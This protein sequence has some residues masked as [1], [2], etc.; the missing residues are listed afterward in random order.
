[1]GKIQ[2]LETQLSNMIAA[3]EV[4]E[5]PA[6]V[7]KELVENAIDANAT[8]IE[9]TIEHAG[10]ILI[11]VRDNGDGMDR[12]DIAQSILRHATSKIKDEYDLFRIKTLGFRGEALPSIASVSSLTIESATGKGPGYKLKSVD[13]KVDIVPIASRKGTSVK[14]ENLFFNTP[15]RLKFLKNDYIETANIIDTITRIALGYPQIAFS[16]FIDGKNSFITDGRGDILQ[17][18]TQ[19]FGLQTA[20]QLTP[21]VFNSH[22]VKVSGYLG[23]PSLAKSHRYALY[24]LVNGRSV[25]L[26]KI[27]QALFEA[28]RPY[29]PPVRYPWLFLHFTVDPSLV[30]VNVHPTK[31]EVRLSKEEQLKAALIPAIRSTLSSLNLAP[32][33]STFYPQN[34]PQSSNQIAP[35]NAELREHELTQDWIPLSL[36]DSKSIQKLTV[37]AQMHLTY[38]V[39]RD[40]QGSIYLIDQ[41]A[42]DE[43]IRYE[44]QLALLKDKKFAVAPLVPVMIDIKPSEAKLLT[45][46]RMQILNS[47]GVEL[48]PFGANVFKVNTVPTWAIQ[49]PQLYIEDL[50]HQLFEDPSIQPDKLRL[51]ALASKACK[52]SIKAQDLLTLNAMQ[53]LI[54][55]LFECQYPYTCPH[56]RPTMVQFSK[57]QLEAMFNRSGF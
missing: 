57:R 35:A 29:L 14:V 11:E 43:R 15:A 41:H 48:A 18:I 1:M 40:E 54:N 27:N 50:L 10:R 49:D 56:G 12:D 52:T 47:I 30:D 26:A 23:L 32:S 55:R 2:V 17:V 44:Q 25:T 19:I 8:R 22:D 37:V 20:K 9:I 21:F 6:S 16:L 24:T 42:A 38:I 3:G 4:V 39:C 51:Y 36:N 53:S 45:E 28:Y 31:K 5:R 33:D 13:G 34:Q 7:I 46:E